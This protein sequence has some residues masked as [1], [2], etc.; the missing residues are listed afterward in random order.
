MVI[1]G[2][3]ERDEGVKGKGMGKGGR[4]VRNFILASIYKKILPVSDS[5]R[6]FLVCSLN[7]SH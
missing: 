3:A 7:K 1:N 6:L 4:I 2:V 5:G